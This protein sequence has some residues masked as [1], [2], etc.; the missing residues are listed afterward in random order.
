MLD[1]EVELYSQDS[2]VQGLLESYKSELE[3][4]NYEKANSLLIAAIKRDLA[5]TVIKK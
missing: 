1:L 2:I 5:L 3:K 4:E